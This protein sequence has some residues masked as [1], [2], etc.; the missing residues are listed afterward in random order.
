MRGELGAE[1][2]ERRG[3]LPADLRALLERYPRESWDAHPNLGRTARFWLDRHGMFR[4]LGRVLRKAL[5]ERREAIESAT[6]AGYGAP[7]GG[8]EAGGGRAFAAFFAP[9]LQ[10]FLGELDAHHHIEDH[11]YFPVFRRAEGSLARGFDLLD[12]DHRTIHEAIERNA[13]TANAMLRALDGPGETG[14]AAA[15]AED[16]DRM[17]ALLLRHLEDEEDLIV[18]VILERTEAWLGI[19]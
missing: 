14:A 10:F 7:S 8:P 5:A 13:R 2:L 12:A 18:P 1:A 11:H 17:V 4:E 3:G 19:G 6:G 9:R 16:T 15:H